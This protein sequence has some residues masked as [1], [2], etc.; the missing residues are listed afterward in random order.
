M[1]AREL[2]QASETLRGL[3]RAV[4]FSKSETSC[5]WDT[6]HAIQRPDGTWMNFAPSTYAVDERTDYQAAATYFATV[7]PEIGL[8]LADWLDGHTNNT[9]GRIDPEALHLARLVNGAA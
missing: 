8:A 9:N 7:G 6:G 4:P 1:S 2:R 5:A 3:A